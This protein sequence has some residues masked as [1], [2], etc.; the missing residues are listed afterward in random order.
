M[1]DRLNPD[2]SLNVDNSLISQDGRFKLVLQQDGNLVL[3]VPGGAARWATATDG[4]KVSRA[5]MQADGNFVL[6]GPDGKDVWASGT[7]GHPGAFLTLQNDGNLVIYGPSGPLWTIATLMP[8]QTLNAPGMLTSQ[9]GRFQF[10][11]GGGKAFLCWSDSALRWVPDTKSRTVSR[12]IMHPDGNFVLYAEDGSPVWASGTPGHP[13]A[14][15]TV[16]NDGNMVIYQSGKPIW[17]TNT[18]TRLQNAEDAPKYIFRLDKFRIDTTRAVHE[19]TDFV[20]FAVK[21]G[22][23]MLEPKIKRLGNLNNGDHT[24][25]LEFGP[26]SVPSTIVPVLLNYQILNS[27]HKDDA[28]TTEL[29]TQGANYLAT[30]AGGALGAVISQV[31][32]LLI[33]LFVADCDGPVA[34]DQVVTDGVALDVNTSGTG[35]MSET[36]RY[37]Y[38]SQTFCGESPDYKV[39]WSII[40]P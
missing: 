29:L 3:Y 25:D 22:D 39:T 31:G 13:G 40:R 6:Y 11:L 4:R 1:S 24:V 16:Q 18:F 21:I 37:R 7:D 35:I 32:K 36:R 17:A 38:E 26:L 34:I 23:Q 5:I 20:S 15:V 19:D 8:N 2:Q 30:A 27:G 14:F 28:Q 12:A 33:G 9:D 10:G